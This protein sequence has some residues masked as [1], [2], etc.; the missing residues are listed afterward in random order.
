MSFYVSRRMKDDEFVHSKLPSRH[1]VLSRVPLKMP[2]YV[3]ANTICTLSLISVASTTAKRIDVGL[4]TQRREKREKRM[5]RATIT[6]DKNND[7]HD[8]RPVARTQM[9]DTSINIK[10]HDVCAVVWPVKLVSMVPSLL[11]RHGYRLRDQKDDRFHLYYF[12]S[13]VDN[14]GEKSSQKYSDNEIQYHQMREFS[15]RHKE[16]KGNCRKWSISLLMIST[17][18]K[19][20][21]LIHGSRTDLFD[22]GIDGM[23]S[24]V[25]IALPSKFLVA[26]DPFALQLRIVEDIIPSEG[27]KIG[28]C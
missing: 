21:P 27:S 11:H 26:F 22:E 28:G 12:H 3:S 20:S 8:V 24:G 10:S 19:L 15:M 13:L 18:N 7:M 6:N 23:L 1:S 9:M 14:G 4:R 2:R 17:V 16:R 5:Q 25:C